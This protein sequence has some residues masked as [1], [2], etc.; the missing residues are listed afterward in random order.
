MEARIWS[1]SHVGAG[2]VVPGG[3]PA[4]DVGLGLADGAVGAAAE[5]LAGQLAEPALDQV[6]P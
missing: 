1:A 3:D 2:V 6:Q 5:F 4:A